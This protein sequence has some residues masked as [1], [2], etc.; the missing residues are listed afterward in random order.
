MDFLIKNGIVYDPSS[1][2]AIKKDISLMDGVIAD[3]I[4][5]YNYRQ[6]INAEGCIVTTG[7]IDYHVHYMRGASESGVQA[8]T[9]SF[10][11]GVTTA[12]D[13]GTAGVGLFEHAYR[14]FVS[15]S[16]V[17][18]LNDL[19]VASGGQSNNKYPENLDPN[20]MDEKK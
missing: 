20:L 16:Q 2:S 17:R 1:H 7:F 9:V 18:F 5:G 15:N 6:E 12:V 13:G 19:L 14:T 3:P 8:D 10:C 4:L 11:S